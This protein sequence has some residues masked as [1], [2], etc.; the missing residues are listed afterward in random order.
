MCFGESYI[1]LDSSS[2]GISDV[3]FRTVISMW[4][5]ITQAKER[6]MIFSAV[7]SMWAKI[8]QVKERP[9]AKIC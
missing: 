5:K 9:Q 3:I 6:P 2:L 8:T 4:A 1:V 7:I